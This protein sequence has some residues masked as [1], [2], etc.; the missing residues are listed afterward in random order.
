MKK[1]MRTRERMR[2]KKESVDTFWSQHRAEELLAAP[3]HRHR[4]DRCE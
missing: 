4:S 3:P 1:K 2:R